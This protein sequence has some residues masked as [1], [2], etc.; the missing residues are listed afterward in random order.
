LEVENAYTHTWRAHLLFDNFHFHQRRVVAQVTFRVEVPLGVEEGR[1]F[2]CASIE[3]PDSFLY[4]F[5]MAGSR[6]YDFCKQLPGVFPAQPSPSDAQ[7]TQ[8]VASSLLRLR[9]EGFYS[10]VVITLMRRAKTRH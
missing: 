7:E 1:Q 9:R 8:L 5:G 10:F 6:P 4:H 2:L 3:S